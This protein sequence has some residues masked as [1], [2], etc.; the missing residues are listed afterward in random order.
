MPFTAGLSY[1]HAG[2]SFDP[3]ATPVVER[4]VRLHTIL[5]LASKLIHQSVWRPFGLAEN[6]RAHFT[7]RAV[8]IER[9]DI[10]HKNRLAN[11]GVNLFASFIICHHETPA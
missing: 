11:Q 6:V 3:N 8:I 2:N 4:S 10:F 9:N 7:N 1:S 5:G